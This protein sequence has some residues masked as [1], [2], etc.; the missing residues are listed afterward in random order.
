[1]DV[2]AYVASKPTIGPKGNVIFHKA[3]KSKGMLKVLKKVEVLSQS[4][5]IPRKRAVV[6]K[7]L[8][9]DDTPGVGLGNREV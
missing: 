8:E 1:M 4:F 7:T 9:R 2:D 3:M 5:R 6:D